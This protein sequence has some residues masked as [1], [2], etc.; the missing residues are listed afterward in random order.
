MDRGACQVTVHGV[1]MTK[2]LTFIHSHNIYIHI[3][4]NIYI[5]IHLHAELHIHTFHVH[6]STDTY[7]HI[8]IYLAALGLSWGTW[9]FQLCYVGSSSLTRD[10]TQAP[11]TGSL[12]SQSLDSQGS[13]YLYT[14]IRAYKRTL[15]ES[16]LCSIC[17]FF[18]QYLTVLT[19]VT[20]QYVLK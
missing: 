19:T 9:I 3:Q 13:S 4:T 1:T 8:I 11:C 2:Q 17:L 7:L 5:Y 18:C 20:F 12:E 14:H 15:L 16:L 10:Q 6:S